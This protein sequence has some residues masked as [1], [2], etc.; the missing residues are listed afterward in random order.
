M[1]SVDPELHCSTETLLGLPSPDRTVLP[2]SS[3]SW[4]CQ[5][6]SLSQHAG[7]H[8]SM[9]SLSSRF[10]L[11]F[12]F[13]S[14]TCDC[15]RQGRVLRFWSLSHS[16]DNSSPSVL[17]WLLTELLS[18]SPHLLCWCSVFHQKLNMAKQICFTPQT[19][20]L[21]HLPI[22]VMATL[23]SCSSRSA[24]SSF[25]CPKS[26]TESYQLF[27]YR[28]SW[29]CSCFSSPTITFKEL[30]LVTSRQVS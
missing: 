23:L 28:V 29:I 8:E 17:L 4:T 5:S 20:L 1:L 13:L 24:F 21:S 25:F 11:L 30:V 6:R 9:F 12:L 27:I 16:S 15:L 7:L 19:V 2:P 3:S 14:F 22:S 18:W 26:S 10:G